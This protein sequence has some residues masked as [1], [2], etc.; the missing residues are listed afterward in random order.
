MH[1]FLLQPSRERE[2]KMQLDVEVCPPANRKNFRLTLAHVT[3]DFYLL[4]SLNFGLVTDGRTDRQTDRKERIR[5][6]HA[7]AQVGSM[8][9]NT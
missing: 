9:P 5:A 4:F 2:K 7:K 6:H 1:L 3:F 8:N